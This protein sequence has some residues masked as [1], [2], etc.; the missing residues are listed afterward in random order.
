MQY[1]KRVISGIF[2]LQIKYILTYKI[3]CLFSYFSPKCFQNSHKFCYWIGLLYMHNTTLA[4]LQHYIIRGGENRG[5][6]PPQIC[7][8]GTELLVTSTKDIKMTATTTWG[9]QWMR[10]LEAGL[11]VM[12]VFGTAVV[13]ERDR[14]TVGWVEGGW[15]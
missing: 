8:G 3:L 1:Y 10:H 7:I 6:S 11:C 15:D 13:V 12:L 5:S 2:L 4:S 9:T 14:P